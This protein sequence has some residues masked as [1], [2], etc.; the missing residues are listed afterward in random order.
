MN[1]HRYSQIERALYILDKSGTVDILKDDHYLLF[2]FKKTER[3]V[4]ALYVLTGLFSEVEPL[5]S[6]IR[7]SCLLLI[8]HMLSFKERT[9][10]HSKERLSES[11]ME[12]AHLSSLIDIAYVSDLLS[13]MNF[14]IFKKELE[15][16]RGIIEGKVRSGN[17]VGV[18]NLFGEDFFGVPSSIFPESKHEKSE[19]NPSAIAKA[20]L[21]EGAEVLH[22]FSDF[23]K[24]R[25]LDVKDIHK[26]HTAQDTGTSHR[27]SGEVVHRRDIV[28]SNKDAQRGDVS[29]SKDERISKIISVLRVKSIAMIKDFSSVIEGCSEKT[30]QRLLIEL[31]R[32]GVLK[33]EGNRRWS[34]YS[35]AGK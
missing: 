11:L 20:G 3:V 4:A 15:T 25:H 28:M 32:S 30:I 8:R 35:I 5:R 17:A 22:S 10:S 9:T 24:Q 18:P 27:K 19:I 16:I 6:G 14:S 34:R 12:M 21:S 23:E 29:Q 31:V 33:R 1:P 7:E 2:L 13:P 26:G